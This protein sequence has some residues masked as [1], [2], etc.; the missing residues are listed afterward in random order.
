MLRKFSLLVIFAIM[1]MAIVGFA[2]CGDDD[3]SSSSGGS[4]T[5]ETTTT[6]DS[7]EEAD[8][9]P[10]STGNDQADAAIQQAIDS[11]KSSID[12]QT[13]LSDGLKEDLKSICDKAASG[14]IQ[15]VQKATEEVCTKIV[16]EMVPEGSARDQ[17]L[18]ACEQTSG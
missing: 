1:G 9:T 7:G 2:G 17:A 15:D 4:T 3:D 6:E 13:T 5:E 8:S 18:S 10:T 14:K 11:C 16:T 12:A